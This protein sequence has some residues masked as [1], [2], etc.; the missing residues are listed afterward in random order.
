MANLRIDTTLAREAQAGEPSPQ[1]QEVQTPTTPRTKERVSSTANALLPHVRRGN[2]DKSPL[3]ASN[4]ETLQQTLKALHESKKLLSTSLDRLRRRQMPPPT[5][6]KQTQGR[7]ESQGGLKKVVKSFSGRGRSSTMD[8]D[9]GDNMQRSRTFM[10]DSDEEET[11][12]AAFYTDETC[13]HM[14]QLR[15]VLKVS[16]SRGW[17]IF[18]SE[19]VHVPSWS[20]TLYTNLSQRYDRRAPSSRFLLI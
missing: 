2:S 4:S 7:T 20:C 6:F 5:S 17:D 12:T 13:D 15:D 9:A 8:K 1:W 14:F 3:A 18:S 11:D 16:L 19:Y 10:D